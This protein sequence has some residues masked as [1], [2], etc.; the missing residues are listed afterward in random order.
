MILARIVLRERG[1]AGCTL[2]HG[3]HG[4]RCTTVGLTFKRGEVLS[5]T[6]RKSILFG[7]VET[8]RVDVYHF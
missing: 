8:M 1:D 4:L 5:L 3:R 2:Q 6:Y 7:V